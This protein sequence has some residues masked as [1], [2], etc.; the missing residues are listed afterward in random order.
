M[1][2]SRPKLLTRQKL[3]VVTASVLIMGAGLFAL[4]V[5]VFIPYLWERALL[6]PFTGV[7]VSA[8]HR[9]LLATSTLMIPQHGKRLLLYDDAERPGP[10]LALE[11]VEGQACWARVLV[12]PNSKQRIQDV[13]LL[14]ISRSRS[15]YK[16]R[17]AC[18]WE[19][20]R[21]AGVVYLGPD[22]SFR[23]FSLSW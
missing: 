13:R 18:D 21:E 2:W 15:G 11:T 20:G 16:V 4:G 1:L 14:S 6:G 10:V 9:P 23:H 3:A 5:K 8:E 17:M 12:V 7:E 19:M 22:L